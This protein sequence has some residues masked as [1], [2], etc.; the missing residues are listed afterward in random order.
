[1]L[2]IR[3]LVVLGVVLAV[4]AGSGLVYAFV[5]YLPSQNPSPNPQYSTIKAHIL[6]GESNSSISSATLTAVAVSQTGYG[7]GASPYG[8][9]G[10]PNP[11][12]RTTDTGHLQLLLRRATFP[13]GSVAVLETLTDIGQ[14]NVTIGEAVIGGSANNGVGNNRTGAEVFDSYV[15][16]CTGNATTTSPIIYANTTTVTSYETFTVV[17]SQVATQQ[18]PVILKPGESFSAYVLLNSTVLSELN[19]IGAGAQ[20]AV[21]SAADQGYEVSASFQKG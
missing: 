12:V 2:N 8:S 9:N 6:G 10:L 14:T 21:G 7:A 19:E 17:C 20:Y 18:G 5:S 3:T 13:N 4:V 11:Y 1:M 15:I 16:G